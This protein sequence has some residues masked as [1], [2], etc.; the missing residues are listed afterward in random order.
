MDVLKET[1]YAK[2]DETG[3]PASNVLSFGLPADSSIMVRP[4][5][6]EP[7]IKLYITAT[8]KTFEEIEAAVDSMNN[9]RSEYIYAI[10]CFSD[11]GKFLAKVKE[12]A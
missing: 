10:T 6:T 2:S 3:L 1:D 9:D 12:D 8:G 11:K 5:G 7:K 4:S